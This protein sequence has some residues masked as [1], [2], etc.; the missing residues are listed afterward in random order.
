MSEFH[1]SKRP[2]TS[3]A[4]T[5]PFSVGRRATVEHDR[6]RAIGLDTVLLT[7][8]SG[9]ETL[10][11]LGDGQ[12]VEM[13]AWRLSWQQGPRMLYRV[14]CLGDGAVGWV[15]AELL[16]AMPAASQSQSSARP[17]AP[18][19]A[20]PRRPR[21]RTSGNPMTEPPAWA[22]PPEGG[23]AAA[24]S[25]R[26]TPPVA[27]SVCGREVHPYNLWRDARGKATG[28]YLCHGKGL[29]ASAKDGVA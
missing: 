13:L 22:G 27:C 3:R 20:P 26:D 21:A 1:F 28:C 18:R 2:K 4:Q 11:M 6:A 7:D 24:D 29:G 19:T 14:S 9:T 10:R 15:R 5:P 25:A 16:R 12:E 23:S 8:E 17:A